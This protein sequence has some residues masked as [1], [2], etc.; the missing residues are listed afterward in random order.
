M[1][2]PLIVNCKNE[3]RIHTD[4]ELLEHIFDLSQKSHELKFNLRRNI[5]SSLLF[6]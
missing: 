5:S 6:L 2:N 1:L 4:G 3:Y